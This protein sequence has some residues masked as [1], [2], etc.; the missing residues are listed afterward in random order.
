MIRTLATPVD[1]L[2]GPALIVMCDLGNRIARWMGGL[3]TA[4]EALIGQTHVTPAFGGKADIYQTGLGLSHS[5]FC[6]R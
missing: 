1:A 6:I 5:I 4:A 2:V 3:N